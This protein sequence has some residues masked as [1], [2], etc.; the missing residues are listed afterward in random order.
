MK[1]CEPSSEFLRRNYIIR[2]TTVSIHDRQNVL[3]L[4]VRTHTTVPVLRRS[5]RAHRP[6]AARLCPSR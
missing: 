4:Q 2:A 6:C 1:V 5:R 3:S